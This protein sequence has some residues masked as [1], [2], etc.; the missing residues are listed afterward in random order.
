MEPSII[1]LQRAYRIKQLRKEFIHVNFNHNIIAENTFET[2]TKMIQDNDLQC[3]I[4]NIISLITNITKYGSRNILSASEFFSAFVIYGYKEEVMNIEASDPL[5]DVN[6]RII[7][8]SKELVTKFSSF[9]NIVITPYVIAQLSKCL[10]Q[11]KTEFE[12]WKF[13]DKQYLIHMLTC[14]YYQL[15]T[16]IKDEEEL[17]Y[18]LTSE[19]KKKAHKIYINICKERKKDLFNKVAGLNGLPYLQNFDPSGSTLD[20][21]VKQ[22]IRDTAQAAFWDIFHQQLSSEPPKYEMLLTLL[23]DLRDRLCNFIPNRPDIHKE[24]YE[25]IDIDLITNMVTNNAFDDASLKKI[26]IYI[27]SKVKSFQPP[28]MDEFVNHWETNM[29]NEFSKQFVYADFLPTFL[30]SAFNM[31]DN[32][33]VYIHQLANEQ[34]S[35]NNSNSPVTPEN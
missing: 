12:S 34:K 35:G 8:K 16:V 4:N 33:V 26:C 18:D 23:T 1:R 15:I 24:I 28:V 3:V 25:S 31:L 21:S 17:G 9:P 22:Q 29:L 30:R 2:F 5:F 19:A 20:I 7:N 14:S 6:S 11:Y 13:R 10:K 27:I 32:I